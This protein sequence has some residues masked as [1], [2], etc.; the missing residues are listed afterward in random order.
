M[1]GAFA[2]TTFTGFCLGGDYP[3]VFGPLERLQQPPFLAIS[4]G[5]EVTPFEGLKRGFFMS[6]SM[7]TSGG[8]SSSI[9]LE[10]GRPWNPKLVE[11]SSSPSI[12]FSASVNLLM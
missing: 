10:E 7:V 12:P 11:N 8:A 1:V 4:T 2:F 3:G 5:L 9:I 6:S